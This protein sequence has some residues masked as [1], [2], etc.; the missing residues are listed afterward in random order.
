M[1]SS[2]AIVYTPTTI[3]TDVQAIEAIIAIAQNAIALAKAGK[4]SQS[5]LKSIWSQVATGVT[6]AESLL[7]SVTS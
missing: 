6:G 3:L 7:N 2:Q 4:I 5:Q 1:E